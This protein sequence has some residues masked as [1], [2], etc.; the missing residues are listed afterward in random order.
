MRR[1]C[2]SA[3][4]PRPPKT[5]RRITKAEAYYNFAMGRLYSEMAAN[6]G[7]KNDYAE[8]AIQYYQDALKLD[9]G[10]HLV[11]EELTDLYIQTGHLMRR[12]DPGRGHAQAGPR[13]TWTRAACSAASTR[14]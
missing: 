2:R 1:S 9:P 8:K 10:S 11:F 7:N 4:R 13:L 14:A 3:N 5:F 6:D 12:G